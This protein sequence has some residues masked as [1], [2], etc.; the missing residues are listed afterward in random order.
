MIESIVRD[1]VIALVVIACTLR[2][3]LD[4]L[5]EIEFELLDLSELHGF[6]ELIDSLKVVFIYSV[7]IAFEEAC[8]V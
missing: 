1:Q 5:L 8:F 6:K 7:S 3:C 4:D 2:Q